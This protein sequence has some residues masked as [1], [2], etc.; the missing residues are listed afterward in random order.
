MPSCV[1]GALCP[2]R[3]A[4]EVAGRERGGEAEHRGRDGE[5]LGLVRV[6]QVV[7]AAAQHASQLPTEVVAVLDA[8]V[9]PLPAG[10]RVDV[11]G[12]ARQQDPTGAEPLHHPRV[13]PVHRHRAQVVQP[14]VGATGALD[15][16]PAQAVEG[17]CGEFVGRHRHDELVVR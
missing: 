17:E 10:R 15:E 1:I 3:T 8:G 16:Q 13:H 2:T 7:G 9:E 5:A 11:C 12:V 6:E 14:E 4:G